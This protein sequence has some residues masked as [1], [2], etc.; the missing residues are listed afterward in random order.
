LTVGVVLP[1]GIRHLVGR[2]VQASFIVGLLAM[3]SY[4]TEYHNV[5][6]MKS[7][8]AGAWWN[9]HEFYFME[10]A[11][12][13]FGLLVALRIGVR[14]AAEA[15]SIRY[16][17]IAAL[18]LDAALLMPLT[19]LCAD[20]ARIGANGGAIVAPNR[21]AGFAGFMTGKLLDKLL[22]AGVYVLKT[23]AFGFLLGLALFGAVLV[24]AIVSTERGGAAI[25]TRPS[26]GSRP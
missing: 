12:T 1:M 8:A 24:I 25:S 2:L 13:A 26:E 11:A 6:R 17:A 5:L 14:L 20:I 21:M 23:T 16:M 18:A 15:D 4:A 19:Y 9:V 3:Y 7:P 10:G 22:L